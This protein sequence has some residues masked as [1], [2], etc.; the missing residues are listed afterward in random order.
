MKPLHA[1]IST[2]QPVMSSQDYETAFYRVKELH[3]LH[4]DFYSALKPRIDSWTCETEVG[5]I[6]GKMVC[7]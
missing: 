6:F 7:C 5:D 1:T 4:S 2:S 3:N